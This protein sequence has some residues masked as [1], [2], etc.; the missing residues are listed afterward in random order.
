MFKETIVIVLPGWQLLNLGG[1][2]S[3]CIGRHFL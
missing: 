1:G 3:Y 2:G